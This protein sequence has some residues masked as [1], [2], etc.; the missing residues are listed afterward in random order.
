[1]NVRGT[2]EPDEVETFLEE[3]T[4]PVRLSC[5]TPGGRLWMVSLWF[6]FRE[7]VLECATSA[8]A[9]VVSFLAADSH[10]AF[11]VS[12]ND[13]PYRGVR[14]NGTAT[15][16]PDPEKEVLGDLLER[17]LGTTESDLADRLLDPDRREVRIEIEPETV[18]GWDYTD[19]MGGGA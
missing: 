9:D 14:G 5:R 19:R 7:G 17:Y 18:A 2:L 15:I 3:T 16:S 1:M 4:V 8:D 10:V 6:R 11:E 13:P 12:T